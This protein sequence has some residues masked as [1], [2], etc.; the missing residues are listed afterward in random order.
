MIAN[1][2][3][4]LQAAA[5]AAL[6]DMWWTV[7]TLVFGAD[8]HS[9]AHRI[10]G[11]ALAVALAIPFVARLARPA[12]GI[13]RR[14]A[15]LAPAV[16]TW[17]LLVAVVH[18][19]ALG[20]L[21]V[22]AAIDGIGIAFASLL[23]FLVPA[24]SLVFLLGRAVLRPSAAMM[25]LAA[26]L[27]A[28]ERIALPALGWTASSLAW[29]ALLVVA[30]AAFPAARARVVEST[31]LRIGSVLGL[32]WGIVLGLL[33]AIARLFLLPHLSSTR[34]SET[35]WLVVAILGLGVGAVL[36]TAFEA[37]AK[38]PVWRIVAF[39]TVCAVALFETAWILGRVAGIQP[40]DFLESAAGGELVVALAVLGIP[41]VLLGLPLGGAALGRAHVAAAAL[42][43]VIG[44]GL[45]PFVIQ[46]QGS[47]APRWIARRA[48]G[49]V[50]E[51][52]VTTD[53][54]LTLVRWIRGQ[55][56]ALVHWN[57]EPL[58]SSAD[59]SSLEREEVLTSQRLA[60]ANGT[61]LFVGTLFA[62]HRE[63]LAEL[64]F[65]SLDLV[66]P[67]PPFRDEPRELAGTDP[68]RFAASATRGRYDAITIL[69]RPALV[70]GDGLLLTR[71]S[72]AR[73]ATLLTP[74]G[75]LFVWLDLRA[76]STRELRPTLRTFIAE[77]PTGRLWIATD[78]YAGP[79]LCFEASI[80]PA[81]D[82]LVP[83]ASSPLFL[84]C[85]SRDLDAH[86][87][88]GAENTIDQPRLELHARL[89]A[90]R[91]G[92]P[93]PESLHALAAIVGNKSGAEP[94]LRA[95]ALHAE[96][97]RDETSPFSTANRRF[98]V[99]SDELKA[100][101]DGLRRFPDFE[102]LRRLVVHVGR[103]LVD[104]KDT[105]AILEFAPHWIEAR[106]EDAQLLY[107]L[108]RTHHDLLDDALALPLLERAAESD[109]DSV[110]VREVLGA[111]YER[112]G[113]WM[114]AATAYQAALALDPEHAGVHEKQLGMAYFEAGNLD[115]ARDYL[116]R[117]KA[118][119]GDDADVTKYL[120]KLREIDQ[121]K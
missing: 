91:H 29:C 101:T 58:S 87:G 54:V 22:L 70:T 15:M 111:T 112:L 96:A 44:C 25:G 90:P 18:T 46:I 24:I 89:V 120:G 39:V 11:I 26:G 108:G 113:R 1:V 80:A 41:S 59:W 2:L 92:L 110:E 94:L 30:E 53:G 74:H 62:A 56:T 38:S 88:P 76:M 55:P 83:A 86:L 71:E 107:V 20:P 81:G 72:L 69:S 67:V 84:A 51:H 109:R 16:A 12:Q 34:F 27:F 45:V 82:V 8:A 95:L 66:D 61:A 117:A 35:A 98:D 63:A 68:L 43:I 42:G 114:D 115:A 52:R 119:L 36:A 118:A 37:R 17:A 100:M 103:L 73:F 32:V 47:L 6:V 116:G 75:T 106:P 78:G 77:F 40:T 97:Q 105:D 31:G 102:P 85:T 50:I 9:T 10:L 65:G 19:R 49:S 104:R 79:L 64:R 21:R 121:G 28:Q 7:G 48:G 57:R 13:G 93:D 14:L 4:F 33:L 60:R 99:S 3:T 5:I 23:A